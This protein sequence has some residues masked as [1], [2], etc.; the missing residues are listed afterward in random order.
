MRS[1]ASGAAFPCA[2]AHATQQAFLEAHELAFHFFQGLFCKL[3]A[4]TNGGCEEGSLKAT[5]GRRQPASSRFGR[6]GD[7]T[8]SSARL[9]KRK[10]MGAW[11][12]KLGAFAEIIGCRFR[13]PL[14]SPISI[15]TYPRPVTWTRHAGSADTIE[16]SVRP[17]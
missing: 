1:M 8:V 4:T 14:T 11:K 3:R 17:C 2:L 13:K 6:G 9:R 10:K 15:G 7:S 5:A 12:A 16:V